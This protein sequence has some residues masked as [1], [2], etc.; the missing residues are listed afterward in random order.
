MGEFHRPAYVDVRK[1]FEAAIYQMVCSRFDYA[2]LKHDLCRG[3][4]TV[5]RLL[6]QGSG[7]CFPLC[8]TGLLS[9]FVHVLSLNIVH[10]GSY[11]EFQA[12]ARSWKEDQAKSPCT[13][14]DPN[15]NG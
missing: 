9:P 12:Q 7:G 11:Q 10:L 8:R 2:R 6:W 4:R 15:E 3:C 5:F 14:V 1:N 13:S